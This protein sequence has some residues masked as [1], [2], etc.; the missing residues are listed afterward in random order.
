MPKNIETFFKKIK[1][2]SESKSLH[3]LHS[4]DE[5]ITGDKSFTL[6]DATKIVES[7]EGDLD[8][9]NDKV[10]TTALQFPL[11]FGNASAIAVALILKGSNPDTKGLFG[12]TTE[13]IIR[14]NGRCPEMSNLIEKAKIFNKDSDDD[15][16]TITLLGKEVMV[17]E[18]KREAKRMRAIGV[19]PR[20][21][22]APRVAPQRVM[23][24][25]EL[26]AT[27]GR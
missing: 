19:E 11:L 27:E 20:S 1:K 14:E 12:V 9:I 2:F 18:A 24:S 21:V 16:E 15:R 8:E 4:S 26:D 22:T 5:E 7:Y 13:S 10:G 17:E 25:M 3:N 6:A 23:A